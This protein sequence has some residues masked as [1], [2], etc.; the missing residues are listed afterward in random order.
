MIRRLVAERTDGKP[1]DDIEQ[2]LPLAEANEIF[3]KY[4]ALV[5]EARPGHA[6][7][8][9]TGFRTAAAV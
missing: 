5:G 8:D 1:F 6:A 7:G 9:T 3:S 2:V 4:H